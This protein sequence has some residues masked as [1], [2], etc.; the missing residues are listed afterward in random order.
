MRELKKKSAH[1]RQGSISKHRKNYTAK[2]VE[3]GTFKSRVEKP[4]RLRASTEMR[5]EPTPESRHV[6]RIIAQLAKIDQHPPVASSVDQEEDKGNA[7][8]TS[9]NEDSI[10]YAQAN[11]TSNTTST[12]QAQV[13][14][15]PANFGKPFSAPARTFENVGVGAPSSSTNSSL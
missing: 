5:R 12:K 7:P 3:D 8:S 15:A 11:S 6:T 13:V 10:E 2:A 9:Q 4:K 14:I 1:Q